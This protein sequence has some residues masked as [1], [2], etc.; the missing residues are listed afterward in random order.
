MSGLST[1]MRVPMSQ[2]TTRSSKVLQMLIPMLNRKIVAGIVITTSKWK[3]VDPAVNTKL[4]GEVRN[5]VMISGGL[6]PRLGREPTV[7]L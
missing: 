6:V 1:K 2:T 7:R 5:M 3:H 4:R